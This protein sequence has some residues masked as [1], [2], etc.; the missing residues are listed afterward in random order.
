MSISRIVCAYFSPT[1]GTKR[2]A[3]ALQKGFL[4]GIKDYTPQVISFNCLTL[5]RRSEHTPQFTANDL[6]VFAYPV[7]Y[8]RMPWALQDWPQL[9]GNGASAIVV[10][11]YGNRAIEDGERETMAMLKK[12][13]FKIVGR[14][15]AIAE[16]SLCRTLAAHRPN[17]QDQAKLRDMTKQI[18]QTIVTA[19]KEDHELKTL[20]FDDQT[21]LKP[22]AQVATVPQPLIVDEST[23]E[24]HK[25]SVLMCPCG[26]IDPE[27]LRVEEANLSQCMNCTVCMHICKANNRGYPEA[28]QKALQTKMAQV[29]AANI[30]PKAYVFE[31]A[32]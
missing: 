20:S 22:R 4:E 30:E 24:C 6:L 15:E 3:M 27:T 11:V 13:G 31:M 2:V 9:Q 10:S 12:H 14:I 29:Q 25:R 7:F 23:I 8:G 18:M 28:M 1:G 17:E 32:Q 26:I 5:A 16:H 19:E 21:P